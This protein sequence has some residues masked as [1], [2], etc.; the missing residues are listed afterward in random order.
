MPAAVC[1]TVTAISFCLEPAHNL[2]T[3]IPP[4]IAAAAELQHLW[5]HLRLLMLESVCSCWTVRCESSGKPYSSAQVVGRFVA[6]L[7]QQVRHDWA[8]TQGDIRINSGVPLSWL[9][10]RNPVMS[11]ERFFF[12]FEVERFR[13]KWRGAACGWTCHAWQASEGQRVLARGCSA[14]VIF[15]CVE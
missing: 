15:L 3:A 7:Q 4:A 2:P 1:P 5:T 8:R 14:A 10:G 9:R 12:F 13:A 11:A 6:V